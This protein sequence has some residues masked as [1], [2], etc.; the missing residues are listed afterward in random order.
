MEAL[1]QEIRH[2]DYL[3][4]VKNAPEISDA[5]YDKRFSR[6]QALEESFPDLRTE[7]SPTQRVGAAPVGALKKAGHAAPMLSLEA[8]REQADIESFLKTVRKAAGEEKPRHVLEPKFD[9]FSVEL[10]YEGGRLVRGVTRGDGETGE[11]ITHNLRT[12]HAVPLVLQGDD[13]PHSLSVRAEVFLPKQA[14]QAINKAR[15]KRGDE[16]FANPRNAAAGMM[17]QLDPGKV[18]GRRLDF[19]CYDLLDSSGEPPSGQT[20]TLEALAAWGLK[21]CPLNEV[22][23]T[24][25]AIRRY[26]DR[27]AERRETLEYEVDGMVIKA[28]SRALREALGVR[29]R[30]PRWAIA[31]KFAPRQEITT[32]EDIV[33]Q[34]GRSGILTPVALLAPVDVGGVTVSRATL[35]NADEVARKDLRVGDTVRIIRAGD[36]IPEVQERIKRPGRKRGKPFAMP[37]RC[38]VCGSAVVRAGAYHRCEAGLSCPAQLA[39]RIRHYA[40]RDALDIAGLGEETAGQLV[41]RGLV[42][43][44]ADVYTLEPARLRQL[45]GYAEKS[46]QQL[47]RAIRQSRKPRLDRFLFALGIPHLGRR[48]ARQ[49]ATRLGSLQAVQQAGRT[50]LESIPDIGKAVAEAVYRFFRRKA[51]RDVLERMRQAGVE[52]QDMPARQGRQPLKGKTFVLTGR[53]E[54]AT[55]NE[56]KEQIEAL[57]GRV[58]ARASSKTDYLVLGERPG[59]KLDEARKL[60]VEILDEQAFRKRVG[61]KGSG[62]SR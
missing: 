8:V 7:D 26:H 40:G 56:A 9:G 21:T 25:D 27:L 35:H 24:I 53:L 50:Q 31:W 51:N 57:G 19:F 23:D 17:R 29:A 5:E 45:D 59:G 61:R 11:D 58:T 39:G 13:P 32:V 28:D 37:R 12:V 42:R 16:A 10:V 43:D 4:Y 14:F 15:L 48:T 3:Y 22:A 6:L 52:V 30:S 33:V 1:R 47:Q 34:V 49:V 41:A 38:P 18:A 44:L 20:A 55:R 54:H 60:G 2:H 36:V 46:A 62:R